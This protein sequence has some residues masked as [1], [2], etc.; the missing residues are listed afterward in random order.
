MILVPKWLGLPRHKDKSWTRVVVGPK[1]HGLVKTCDLYWFKIL[2][3]V[4][5]PHDQHLPELKKLILILR[6]LYVVYLKEH[7]MASNQF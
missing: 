3:H 6:G 5:V 7:N 2:F 4:L 1:S